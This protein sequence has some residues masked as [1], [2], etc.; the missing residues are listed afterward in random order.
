MTLPSLPL[1]V[2]DTET[3]G[4][5]P[6]THRVIEFACACV[7]EGEVIAEYEQLFFHNGV[8]PHVEVLTHIKTNDLRDAPT[9][10]E[11][12]GEILKHLPEDALLVGQNISFDLGMLKGEGMDL[13][14]RPWI[15]TSM[16]ASLV[17]PELES[18]SL[19]YLS[20]VLHLNH[21]PQHRA[22]GDVHATLELLGK[23][24]ERLCALPTARA[25]EARD[26]L[27]RSTSG[28]R[29]L[30]ETLPK[31][32]RKTA[33]KWLAPIPILAS[34]EAKSAS[35][36]LPTAEPKSV[37][38]IEEPLDPGH[39]ASIIVA[40]LDD[41][42]RQHWIAVKNLDAAVARL[43]FALLRQTRQPF[44][45]AQGRQANERTSSE[46]RIL[47]PHR[48]LLDHAAADA[49]IAQ[50]TFTA[51]EA[52]LALKL[53]W[54]RPRI[55]R[56]FPLHGGEES[57]WNGKV[58]CTAL[59]QT[60][61][62]QFENLPAVL[63]LD[64]HQL[65]AIVSDPTHPAFEA[66]EKN[67]NI[68]VDD[69][70]MLEDTATK[71]FGWPCAIDDLRA[72]SEGNSLLTKFLDIFQLWVEKT[73]QFQDIR[74]LAIGDLKTP[75]ARGLREQLTD[76]RAQGN[77][78]EQIKVQFDSLAQILDPDNLNNR[79]AWIEQRQNGNQFLHCVPERVG[80]YLKEHLFDRF[81]TILLIP[82][83]LDHS[84]PEILPQESPRQRDNEI[85]KQRETLLPISFPTDLT[86]ETL[87]TNP[88]SGKSIILLPGKSMIENLYVK[89]DEA[90]E[91]ENATL[92]CQGLSGGMGRMQAEFHA[93]ASPALWLM[94]PWTFEGV[95]LPEH[96][97]DHLF[98]RSLPFDHPSSPV[99]SKRSLHYRDAFA[100]YSLP[101]LLHRLFRLLRTFMRFRTDGGD[102]TFFDERLW[103]KAYG[104]RVRRYL[105]HFA[106]AESP[107]SHFDA[108]STGAVAIGHQSPP[109]AEHPFMGAMRREPTGAMRKKKSPKKSK[110]SKDAA[111]EGQLSL[112]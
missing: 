106:S 78:S 46:L 70:S 94:T 47:Y 16:L 76:V 107:P 4:F 8:P 60:Y 19:G 84:L 45:F 24:W 103:S 102:V 34:S 17:F 61:R 99:F 71:A 105:A 92:I 86:V 43:P 83:H 49:L 44:D 59:A 87:L 50:K 66:I 52:T 33:P 38:L 56:E 88:P 108:S 20:T 48:Q 98:L 64:H 22:M 11:C 62:D 81:G 100:E 68:I 82:S 111:R 31:A 74:Y 55:R 26:I 21:E 109:P 37:A 27:G 10:E 30:I 85:T 54:Y 25:K 1:V 79:I 13:S 12:R 36:D 18:Y 93:A 69:A 96:C 77:F 5:V 101:R 63:L 15:D 9:F 51:D 28:Y 65:L 58:A 67:A 95:D 40:T 72:A 23:C 90:L 104:K 2:L 14:E 39:L 91:A 80:L 57:V 110:K 41:G 3:T 29:M 73:R 53:C 75:E 32:T 7:D 42:K 112:F 35:V 89:F 6:R 97:V